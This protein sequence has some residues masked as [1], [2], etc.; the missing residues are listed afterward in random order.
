MLNSLMI[1]NFRIFKELEIDKIS[2]HKYSF[3]K[4]PDTDGSILSDNKGKPKIGIWIMPNNLSEGLLEDFLIKMANKKALKAAYECIKAVKDKEVAAFKDVY[5]NKAV[6]HT[7]LAW[8]NE[9]GKPLGQS[10]TAHALKPETKIANVFIQWLKKI[11][12]L[13]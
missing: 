6:I 2:D 5:K 10:I 1:R 8:Q 7:Y 11:I 4:V 12:L 3:S 9:Q 13:K